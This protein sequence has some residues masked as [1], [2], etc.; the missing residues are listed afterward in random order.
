MS[1]QIC[2]ICEFW[3]STTIKSSSPLKIGQCYY[4]VPSWVST[5]LNYMVENGGNSCKV[6][7]KWTPKIEEIKVAN[8]R[9]NSKKSSHKTALN[10][11]KSP[12]IG[13]YDAEVAS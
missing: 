4:P 12:L 11:D 2:K 7:S 10:P 13:D 8:K 3:R 5:E 6:F 1:K 9:G